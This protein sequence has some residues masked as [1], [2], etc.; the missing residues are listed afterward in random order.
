MTAEIHLAAVGGDFDNDGDLDLFVA[1]F[2]ENNF[3][4]RNDGSG[5]FVK[6]HQ[7]GCSQ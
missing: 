5:D 6:N 3:L 1:N 4:Y 7:R 2:D